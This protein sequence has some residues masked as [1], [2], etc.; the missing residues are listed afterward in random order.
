MKKSQIKVFEELLQDKDFRG[1]KALRH[2]LWL[3]T[4]KP[5]FN[6]GDC[7]KVSDSGH[8]VYGYPVRDFNAKV[9]SIGSF[10][11]ENEWRYELEAYVECDGKTTTTKVYKYES[12]LI[13]AKKCADN[14]NVLGEAKSTA[15]ESLDVYL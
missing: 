12:E 11:N 4:V 7:F 14:V 13:R 2:L 8:R 10:F 9:I 5:K 15:V 6:E 3:N 1:K